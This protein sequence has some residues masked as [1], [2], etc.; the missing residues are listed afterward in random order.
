MRKC[1][2]Y[3]VGLKSCSRKYEMSADKMMDRDEANPLR[4]LSAYFMTTP[5]VKPLPACRQCTGFKSMLHKTWTASIKHLEIMHTLEYFFKN[6]EP[7]GEQQCMWLL[8]SLETFPTPWRPSH[9]TASS[10]SYRTKNQKSLKD[11]NYVRFKKTT[12]TQTSRLLRMCH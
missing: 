12:H 4:M 9:Y 5:M 2:L 10:P 8:C 6:F 3:Q 1:V 7:A 11:T